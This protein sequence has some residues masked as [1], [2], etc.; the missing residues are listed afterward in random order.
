[1]LYIMT[2]ENPSSVCV[3]METANVAELQKLLF[4][5]Y[6]KSYE[7][8]YLLRMDESSH[9]ATFIKPAEFSDGKYIVIGMHRNKDLEEYELKQ[10]PVA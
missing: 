5:N 6:I 3:Q 1:M 8:A 10:S 4:H 9:T 2:L 7:F